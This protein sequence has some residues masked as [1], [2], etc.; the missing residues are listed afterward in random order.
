MRL[1]FNYLNLSFIEKFLKVYLHIFSVRH[2]F[3]VTTGSTASV[4]FDSKGTRLLCREGK[5]HGL[6]QVVLNKVPSD[7]QQPR[8]V[9]VETTELQSPGY[10]VP[11]MG[12][13][14]CCF[15]GEEDELVVAPSSVDHSLH[16][17]SVCDEPNGKRT[18]D[19]SLLPLSGH[20][21]ALNNLRY[22]KAISTLA[23]CGGE[24]VIKLWTPNGN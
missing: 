13:S 16:I 7:K 15:A 9:Q 10:S 22:S 18:I 17:W 4:T 23:S 24:S 14:I 12:L 5:S 6:L 11:L 19:Q 21:K 8:P 20:Q 1:L 2:L 3:P